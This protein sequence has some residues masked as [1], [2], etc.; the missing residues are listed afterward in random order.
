MTPTRPGAAAGWGLLTVLAGNML[1]DA[2]EVSAAVVALPTVAGRLHLTLT[3]AQWIITAFAVG[4][5][6]LMPLGGRVVARHG[7]RPVYLLALLGFAAASL[8]GGLTG[9]FTVLVVSRFVKGGCAALTAPTGLAI[10]GGSFPEGPARSRALAVYTLFGAGGFTAGLLLSGALTEESWRWTF[11]APAPIVLALFLLGLRVIPRSRPAAGPE[12]GYDLA[13]ALCL[14]AAAAALV[15]GITRLPG[16]GWAQARVLVPAGAGL[17]LLAA[18][19]V[20][21]RRAAHPLLRRPERA[22]GQLVRAAS[23]AGCLNG[24]YLGLLLVVTVQLQQRQGWSPFH[25]ALAIVPASGPLAVTALH[26]G[27]LVARFGTRRLIA[28]GALPPCLGYLLYLRLPAH[29]GYPDAVLPTMLLVAAGFVLAFA[30]LNTQATAG[31]RPEERAAGAALYQST[32][33]LGAVLVPAAVAALL[34]SRLPAHGPAPAAAYRPALWLVTG[35]GTAGLLVA[36]AGL[37]GT[38]GRAAGMPP[39]TTG[40]PGRGTADPGGSDD[41]RTRSERDHLS[42]A[43]HAARAAGGTGNDQGRGPRG[44]GPVRD[45]TPARPRQADPPRAH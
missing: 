3:S 2:L 29:A 8:A 38:G 23:G 40:P 15:A 9:S 1:I 21:E 6:G 39:D 16:G 14:T 18:V 32:V 35:V 43:P 42:G 34:Q 4:F 12:V 28:A 7:S 5:G 13:G 37:V 26:S 25:T 10:I 11:A 36:L 31:L 17:L 22:G 19:A 27:R 33:Q 30:A 44:S 41:A 20:I 45:R 24:S